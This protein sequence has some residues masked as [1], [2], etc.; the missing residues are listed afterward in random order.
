MVQKTRAIGGTMFLK[1]SG[2]LLKAKGEFTY[3]EGKPKRESV[4]GADNWHGYTEEQQPA[5]V[6]GAIT[7]DGTIRAKDI[8]G[9]VDETI[10]LDLVNGKT[11]VLRNSVYVGEGT[12]NTSTGEM[13]FRCEGP[14]GEEIAPN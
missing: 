1:R 14:S 5:F 11:F 6:E 8:T 12:T 10:T 2:T 9:I 4:M 3:N 13:G 7:N